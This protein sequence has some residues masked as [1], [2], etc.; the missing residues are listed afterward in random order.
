MVRFS[1]IAVFSFAGFLLA[2]CNLPEK[3]R[4]I[5]ENVKIADLATPPRKNLDSGLL[6]T[7]NFEVYIIDI[8]AENIHTLDDIWLM[9]Q[10][11]P[12]HFSDYQ[13]FRTNLFLA[14]FGQ[15]RIRNTVADLL[16]AGRK[17]IEKVSLI[18]SDGQADEFVITRLDRQ[19]IFYYPSRDTME[20]QTVGPGK[21]VLR[22]KAEKIP[23]SRGVCSVNI[24]PVFLPPI[25]NSI[26]QLATPAISDEYIFASVGFG[27]RMSP[28]D[29]V[30]LAP[31]KYID[32]QITVG[33]LFFRSGL[34]TKQKPFVR[35]Y[36]IACNRIID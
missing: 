13:S 21:L 2:G 16:Y 17:N 8:P 7:M 30:F 14:G 26:P 28:G 18:L 10:T 31:E 23:G 5:W 29:F 34:S 36:L 19:T 22:I 25:R 32:N 1:Q 35:T 11:H 27:L 24:L 9:L 12:L 4:P 33:G 15:R 20:G 3:D 6:K